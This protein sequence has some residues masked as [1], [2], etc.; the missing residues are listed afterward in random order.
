MGREW[1]TGPTCG[2]V[3]SSSGGGGGTGQSLVAQIFVVGQWHTSRVYR[4]FGRRRVLT[5]SYFLAAVSGTAASFIPTLPLYC[6]FRFLV[7]FAVAGVMM[8]SATLCM[9]PDWCWVGEA[10][11]RSQE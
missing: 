8:S 11:R 9:S 6:L 3:P 1:G 5:W 10:V 2:S 4:R 7:A